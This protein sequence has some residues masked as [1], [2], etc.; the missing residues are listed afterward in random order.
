[1]AAGL[2]LTPE[3]GVNRLKKL[4]VQYQERHAFWAQQHLKKDLA[5]AFLV[6]SHAPAQSFFKIAIAEFAPALQEGNAAGATAALKK[7]QTVYETHRAAIDKAVL[8][9]TALNE[10]EEGDARSEIS[11]NTVILAAIFCGSLGLAIAVAGLLVRKLLKELGGE[12]DEA[13][14]IARRIASGDLSTE[15]ALKNGDT[16]SLLHAIKSMQQMLAGTVSVI[17][18]SVDAVRNGSQEIAS[19]NMDLSARTEHHASAIQQTAATLERLTQTIQQTATS[20]REASKLAHGA[21]GIAVQGGTVMH[22]VVDIMAAISD[23]SDRITEITTEIDGIAFQTN[24]LSLNAAVEA[25]RAGTQGAGFAVV[26][27]EVRNLAQRSAAASKRIRAL[28][29]DATRDVGAGRGLVH[30]ASR[31]MKQIVDSAGEVTQLIAGISKVTGEQ[32]ASLGEVNAAVTQMGEVTQQ[33]AALVEEAAAASSSLHEQAD[34]LLALANH[35]TVT[36]RLGRELHR[37]PSTTSNT[38]NLS[39]T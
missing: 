34:K 3:I 35:F 37:L 9:V 10:A 18:V 30:E 25:A 6:D 32:S 33:N 1:M 19:G 20:A 16:S 7:M 2:H 8:I 12:P 36:P 4:Q 28:I 5:D 14:S 22:Q 31:T 27:N 26:A 17:Q 39:Y 29:D 11:S 23:S 15:I 38:N 21:S 24:I 13:A